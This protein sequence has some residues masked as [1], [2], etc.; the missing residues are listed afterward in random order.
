MYRRNFL[1]V[2]AA[3]GLTMLSP[4]SRHALAGEDLRGFDAPFWI[5]INLAGAWDSTQFC[6]PKGDLTDGTGHGAVNRYTQAD[7]MDL[8]VGANVIR[9]APGTHET[10][11][12]SYYHHVPRAGGNPV[13]FLNHL[14]PRGVTILNGVDAG[15]TNHKSGEQLAMSGSTAA[16][17]PTLPALLAYHRL[18]DRDPVPN[19]PMPLLSFGGYDGTGNLVP[20]TRLSRLSVLGQITR[21]DVIGTGQR[22]DRRIH[23]DT[24]SD[25]I[26]AAVEGR[27]DLL[28]GRA[29]LPS[30]AE[31]M[32]QLFVARS[33]QR[34]VR[35]LL[36]QFD[37][38]VFEALPSRKIEQQA[39]VAL[40]AF[41]GGLAVGA[42]FVLNGW[43]THSK[44]DEG[45]AKRMQDLFR[46]LVY[47]KDEAEHLG[48][49]D[50]INIMVGS[51]FGRTTYYKSASVDSGKDHHSVTSW[52][53][54]LW[55]SG[56]ESGVRVIGE[57]TDGVV[58]RGLNP[59]LVPV[60][61]DEGVV[62]TPAL[63]H[64]DL[65]RLAGLGEGTVADRFALDA[66]NLQIWD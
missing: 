43:D 37:F 59:Q 23:G 10:I 34:H 45:Q 46:A 61:A 51:D 41:E 47:I 66:A 50:R 20:A 53:T 35:R 57:T 62:L 40:R 24:R 9:L 18:V 64:R 26:T 52:M 11:E 25:L 56:V 44:N 22:S 6:D 39:Y 54:M 3:A 28:L 5:T 29:A 60:G 63:I 12:G 49:A 16:D 2:G 19:G 42:N 8:N 65:R 21:P 13:H 1:K 36:Q 33:K 31:A 55:G 15:L 7:I 30:K 58:A 27:R 14:A 38:D 17:F 48:I 32:S 4:W